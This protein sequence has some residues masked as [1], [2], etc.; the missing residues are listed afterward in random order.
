L[1]DG[2]IWTTLI[3]TLNNPRRRRH[4]LAFFFSQTLLQAAGS[5]GTGGYL[6]EICK[7]ILQYDR[8]DVD[9]FIQ[10]TVTDIKVWTA[11]KGQGWN[12][13]DIQAIENAYP[14]LY[15]DEDCMWL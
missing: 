8:I 3:P 15:T 5:V 9:N 12:V 2:K 6:V 14:D 13:V 7:R 1:S 11:L 10:S 4:G